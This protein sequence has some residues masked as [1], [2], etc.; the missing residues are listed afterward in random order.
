M[1]LHTL[2]S[3]IIELT[4]ASKQVQCLKHMEYRVSLP[5]KEYI[6]ATGHKFISSVN[7]TLVMKASNFSQLKKL[8][9]IF[10]VI[11]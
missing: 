5:D 2:Q 10:V 7:T 4:V 1:K 6:I 11:R 3:K 9:S 8:I